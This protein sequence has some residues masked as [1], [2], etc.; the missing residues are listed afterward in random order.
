GA[1][2]LP[3]RRQQSADALVHVDLAART[4]ERAATLH[5]HDVA[6]QDRDL[7]VRVIDRAVAA[8]LLLAGVDMDMALGLHLEGFALPGRNVVAEVTG[9]EIGLDDRAVAFDAPQGAARLQRILVLP[10]FQ[11]IAG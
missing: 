1:N 9:G 5:Q 10:V 8:R 11:R 7:G 4:L 2:A 3:R 6:G